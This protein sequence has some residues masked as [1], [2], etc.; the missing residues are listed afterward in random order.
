MSEK[1]KKW[2]KIY[3]FLNAETKPKFH[4]LQCTKERK[5]LQKNSFLTKSGS[6]GLKKTKRR[7]FYSSCYSD[8]E[9]P[10]NVIKEAR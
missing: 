7:I 3:D 2:Q 9:G 8:L 10:Q 5:N 6:W 4:C 1:E